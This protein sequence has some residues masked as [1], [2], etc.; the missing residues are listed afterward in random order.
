MMETRCDFCNSLLITGNC[1]NGFY[2]CDTCK[3]RGYLFKNN[4]K[5]EEN[6][7]EEKTF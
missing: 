4:K 1:R 2:K 3:K 5:E 6:K 7:N